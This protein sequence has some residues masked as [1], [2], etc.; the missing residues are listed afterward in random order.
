M[1]DRN[2]EL[3]ERRLKALGFDVTVVNVSPE[4]RR[5]DLRTS[6]DGMIMFVEVKTRVTNHALR[7]RMESVAVGDMQSF[8]VPLDKKNFLSNYVK[9]ANAQLGAAASPADFRLLWFREDNDLFVH[10][11]REQIGTTLLGMR[12]VAVLR[13]G[14][15]E[16]FPCFYAAP[17]DFFRYREIDG[18]MVEQVDG[19]LT[20]FLNQ[21]SPREAA[22]ASSPICQ[23]IAPAIVDVRDGDRLGQWY[24][25]DSD[26]DRKDDDAL[27]SFLRK[28]YQAVDF[29]QFTPYASGLSVEI[30]KFQTALDSGKSGKYDGFPVLWMLRI[31]GD[32][33]PASSSTACA[34]PAA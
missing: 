9:K 26:V 11:F 2:V 23:A 13:D 12:M 17:A 28:K 14:G 20:L 24:V 21:F 27:L 30:L 31:F 34:R 10:D 33:Y 5:P 1:R 4:E 29:L 7:R 18:A 19:A 16:R 15:S 3:V 8:L 25:I 22:F 6:K 32:S